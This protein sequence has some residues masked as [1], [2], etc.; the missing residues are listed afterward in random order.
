M[1]VGILRVSELHLVLV[2]APKPRFHPPLLVAHVSVDRDPL[3][4]LPR[5]GARRWLLELV[6]G[7]LHRCCVC[8]LRSFRGYLLRRLH[9]VLL[10]SLHGLHGFHGFHG[11]WGTALKWESWCRC[12]LVFSLLSDCDRKQ[13]ETNQKKKYIHVCIHIYIY[14]YI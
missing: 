8:L 10:R 14:I 2:S 7:E 5:Q 4:I 3:S 9:G 13:T 1:H 11:C 12:S 6:C